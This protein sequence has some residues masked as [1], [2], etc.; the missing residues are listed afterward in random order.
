M[1]YLHM[2]A[3][4]EGSISF[5]FDFGI[6]V[7]WGKRGCHFAGGPLHHHFC[8]HC[9]SENLSEKIS[10]QLSEI[11]CV[12]WN[13]A[14]LKSNLVYDSNSFLTLNL[15]NLQFLEWRWMMVIWTNDEIMNQARWKKNVHLW[16]AMKRI[17]RIKEWFKLR[18]F[19]Q[20]VCVVTN[21]KC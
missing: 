20:N 8:Y 11:C 19:S 17:V 13:V 5:Y 16:F 14:K 9:F 12:K 6:A 7:G 10:L 4:R 1:K 15:N 2:I 21:I 18:C 3:V